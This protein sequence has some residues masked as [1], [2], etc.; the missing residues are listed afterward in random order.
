MPAAQG[1]LI[2]L[3]EAWAGHVLMYQTLLP[4]FLDLMPVLPPEF[5]ADRAGMSPGLSK[6][7]VVAGAPHALIQTCLSLG[8]LET[9]LRN[10]PF[11]LGQSF[12]LADACC[13]FPLWLFKNSPRLFATIEARASVAAWFD[14]IEGFGPG[15]TEPM[16]AAEALEIAR[17]SEPMAIAANADS[18]QVDGIGVGDEI[19]ILA[20]DYGVEESCGTVVGLTANAI[21]IRRRDPALGD[22]A[23]HFPRAGYRLRKL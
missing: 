18:I 13:F 2:A 1:G 3:V 5:L 8:I 12:T 11:V 17:E 14:R 22:L 15:D 10:Q 19:A 16:I 4:T 23:V 9:L 20:D 6:D 21:S 7:A